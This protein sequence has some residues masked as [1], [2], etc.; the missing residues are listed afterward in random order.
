MSD[1][2]VN[3][4]MK[5]AK[6]VIEY[7][8][9]GMVLGVGSGTTVTYFIEELG[10][11]ISKDNLEILTVPSSYD[12][13][14]K[15]VEKGIKITTLEEYSALDLAVDGADEIDQDLN[16]IKGG[17]GCLF[18]EKIVAD[19]AE[20][21]M[22]IADEGKLVGRLGEKNPV[23]VEVHPFAFSHVV[24]RIESMGG[25]PVVRAANK[26][27][28]GPV[29]TDNGNFILDVKF[30]EIKDPK[31]LEKEL[32]LIPGVIENGLFIDM[33][34]CAIIATPQKVVIKAQK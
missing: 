3:L 30:H 14:F 21:F 17:G 7:V 13:R 10:K 4:K 23:P 5:A 12:T 31:N 27:K 28:V 15:L 16:L 20:E 8:K 34:S 22:V 26:G 11:R 18:L 25:K 1:R 2:D 9:D 6:A 33:V 29:I 32:N 19:A 24:K